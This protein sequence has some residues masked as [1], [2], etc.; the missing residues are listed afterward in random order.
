MLL[1]ET[2]DHDLA[3]ILD[4]QRPK[5][6]G[7]NQAE[8]G[9]VGADAQRQREHGYRGESEVLAKHSRGKANILPER[10]QNKLLTRPRHTP[11]PSTP[12][13]FRHP[14]KI[15]FDGASWLRRGLP[16]FLRRCGRRRGGWCALRSWR[17]AG[18][19]SPC[20]WWRHCDA[21]RAAVP[22]R[23]RRFWSPSFRWA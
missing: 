3:G 21:S 12:E 14:G 2:E 7:I 4:R 8:N 23:L 13:V 19:V 22:S 10:S 17:S 1:P 16:G 9:G 20:K 15:D 11:I 6:Q 18:R 5:Q